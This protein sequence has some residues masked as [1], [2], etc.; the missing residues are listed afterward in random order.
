MATLYS[1]M[2]SINREVISTLFTVTAPHAIKSALKNERYYPGA[3]DNPDTLRFRTER[4]HCLL[5]CTCIL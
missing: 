3:L 5:V 4:H 1:Y 2:A